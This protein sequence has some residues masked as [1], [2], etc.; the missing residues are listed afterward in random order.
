PLS[1][2]AQWAASPILRAMIPS[3]SSPWHRTLMPT[4]LIAP[5]VGLNA[6]TPQKLAG[7]MIEPDVC[8]PNARGTMPAATAAQEP[9]DEPPGVCAGLCGLR[10]L[11]GLAMA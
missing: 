1:A 9:D 8:V 7:R 6:V 3:V 10:V 11:L 2:A 5:K 4:V